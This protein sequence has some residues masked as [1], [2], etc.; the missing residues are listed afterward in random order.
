MSTSGKRDSGCE[1]SPEM[2]SQHS[3]RILVSPNLREFAPLGQDPCGMGR[4]LARRRL[5][6]A[7]QSLR[8]PSGGSPA[9]AGFHHA[10][11]RGEQDY[12]PVSGSTCELSC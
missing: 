1:L 10:S 5:P 4:P 2:L 12:G 3:T 11:R 9:L 7:G 8:F 6:G